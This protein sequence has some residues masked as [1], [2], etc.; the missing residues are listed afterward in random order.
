MTTCYS[1]IDVFLGIPTPLTSTYNQNSC[2]LI[3]ERIKTK[4]SNFEE[5]L[6]SCKSTNNSSDL[7]ATKDLSNLPQNMHWEAHNFSVH[8]GKDISFPVI[9]V[10]DLP[11]HVKKEL[12]WNIKSSYLSSFSVQIMSNE[13]SID[14]KLH[15]IPNSGNEEELSGTLELPDILCNLRAT[16]L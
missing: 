12:V 14:L 10:E 8:A 9:M 11:S 16:N 13:K 6:L 7:L 1:Q 15:S 3:S 4:I 2:K 5:L